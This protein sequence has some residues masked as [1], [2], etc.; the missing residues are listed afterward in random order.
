[1]YTLDIRF[2][3][4]SV[5][6]E[7]F[8][9]MLSVSRS[10]ALTSAI[11]AMTDDPL[12]TFVSELSTEE[13]VVTTFEGTLQGDVMSKDDQREDVFDPLVTSKLSF[14]MACGAFPSW[15]M[16]LCNY[17]TDVRVLLYAINPTDDSAEER[18]RGYL[19]C[20]ALNM[21]VVNDKMACPLIAIDE[22]AVAKYVNLRGTITGTPAHPSI[23]ELFDAWHAI[24]AANF[25]HLYG[26]AGI[27]G[28]EW[29]VCNRN[30]AFDNDS[31][32]EQQYP[33]SQL[34]I[35][36]QRYYLLGIGDGEDGE[37]D[38]NK[39]AKWGDV[40]ADVCQ[41][42]GVHW[43]VGTCGSS[44]FDDHC[45]HYIIG[46]V[47]TGTFNRSYYK[48][49]TAG[50]YG[51]S[52]NGIFASF[53]NQQKI[54]A[55]LQLTY[56]QDKYKG[57]RVNSEGERMPIHKYL[58]QKRVKTI[59]PASG[60]ADGIV[61]RLGDAT[62]TISQIDNLEYMKLQYTQL[63]SHEDD[64]VEM[65][66]CNTATTGRTVGASGYFP[67][68][69]DTLGILRPNG[70]CTDSLDFIMSHWGMITVRLGEY[71]EDDAEAVT[72]MEEWFM[73]LNNY[74]GR[75]Y[76][77][78]DSAV[79]DTLGTESK[80][81]T[82]FPF[83]TDGSLMPDTE[84][85]LS[86]DFAAYFLNE[87][88]GDLA[89]FDNNRVHH[90]DLKGYIQAVFPRLKS[91]YDYSDISKTPNG[92][93]K[94]TGSQVINSFY[95]YIKARL[96]IGDQWWNGSNWEYQADPANGPDFLLPLIPT[97]VE[98]YWIVVNGG[99]PATGIEHKNVLNYYYTECRPHIGAN[100]GKFLVPLA[101]LSIHGQ[102][103]DGR[104]QLEL[105]GRIDSFKG[106]GGVGISTRWN[107]LLFVMINDI[108]IGV[109]DTAELGDKDIRL[110]E[111][112]ETDAASETKE[113]KEVDFSLA[114]PQ[115]DGVFANALLFDGGKSW[116]YL[117]RI[118]TQGGGSEETPE[119]Y[120]AQAQA[121]VYN[122]P[123]TLVEFSR[124]MT[125]IGT[126]NIYN[127]DFVV[128]DLTEISG[129]FMPIQRTFVWTKSRVRWKMQRLSETN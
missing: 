14:N 41:Y 5:N 11:A 88:I 127:S 72:H 101:G 118:H 128:H 21:T 65:E 3:F 45:H 7:N 63:D 40:F 120:M 50:V 115:A 31:S 105:I 95:P 111:T 30:L 6:D 48:F 89:F 125:A 82:F 107:N 67:W 92:V 1:M 103:L 71:F 84:A 78:K 100:D 94:A 93:L 90:A 108:N 79:S 126:D 58:E 53:G 13:G 49:G 116:H 113:L 124:P 55:D 87:N 104:V 38:P 86:I 52:S 98:R 99:T 26:V 110:K 62:D 24:H 123:N 69:D 81:A 42:L 36:L 97:D 2:P 91:S 27:T 75:L 44:F 122:K 15:I 102:P 66:D 80:V 4:S 77:D 12:F 19:Q 20:N 47:D 32:Q 34:Y 25:T 46:S 96:R 59:T 76:W 39:A 9:L 112:V 51:V 73:F 18:W 121:K 23:W 70:N 109:T 68:T 129:N 33:L 60:H 83:G 106:T 29:L 37:D 56:E 28:D 8:M 74:W 117:T 64:Y 119:L 114:T 54:G 17:Y 85:Y 16:N 22:V 35:N 57:V 43:T 61:S 10:G